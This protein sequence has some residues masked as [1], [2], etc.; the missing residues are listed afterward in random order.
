MDPSLDNEQVEKFDSVEKLADY[1]RENRKYFPR[2]EAK[3]GCVLRVL[4]RHLL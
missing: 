2:E 1:S 4:L 3:A